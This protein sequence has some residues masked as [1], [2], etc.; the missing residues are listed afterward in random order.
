[1]YSSD[2]STSLSLQNLSTAWHS[3]ICD[4]HVMVNSTPHVEVIKVN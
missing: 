3:T 4:V 2:S 1:M